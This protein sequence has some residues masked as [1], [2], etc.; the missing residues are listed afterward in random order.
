MRVA[1]QVRSPSKYRSRPP[2]RRAGSGDRGLARQPAC[3]SRSPVVPTRASRDGARDLAQVLILNGRFRE[4]LDLT[5][6]MQD[7]AGRL[8][9]RALIESAPDEDC[10]KSRVRFSR[11]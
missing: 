9:A 8:L 10:D 3:C 1:P 4:A 5:H 6:E 7:E 11:C 2:S